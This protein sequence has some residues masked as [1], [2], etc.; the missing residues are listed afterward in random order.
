MTR[1]PDE[2]LLETEPGLQAG[3]LHRILRRD[4]E[5]QPVETVALAP[6]QPR[7]NLHRSLDGKLL[8]ELGEQNALVDREGRLVFFPGSRDE[9]HEL[10]SCV[11]FLRKQP[12]V[13]LV[14]GT[15][16]D[17]LV[18]LGELLGERRIPFP[19][20]CLGKIAESSLDP[21]GRLVEY[22][23][24]RLP[25]KHLEAPP[26]GRLPRGEEALEREA[27]GREP[28]GAERTH[29]RA[30]AGNGHD[31]GAGLSHATHDMKTGVADERGPRVAHQGEALSFPEALND[32]RRHPSLIVIVQGVESGLN[33]VG[34]EE[35]ASMPG[36]FGE[37][38]A[39]LSQDGERTRADV[40]RIA[41]GSGYDIQSAGRATTSFAAP[42]L[43][44]HA[45]SGGSQT[46]WLVYRGRMSCSM[47]IPTP[48]GIARNQSPGWSQELP[49]LLSARARGVRG[50]RVAQSDKER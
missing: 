45:R 28:R 21:V 20:E 30:G 16:A 31:R 37:N 7:R 27:V 14:E 18:A 13:E 41:D 38:R 50:E 9:N 42:A 5:R 34:G 29:Q 44:A 40:A 49:D 10:P 43:P 35:A 32:L 4:L 48:T 1:I 25:A 2:W 12:L 8:Q 47:G 36:I 26:P 22:E 11:L 6:G 3:S 33:P 15:A 23:G 46:R 39:H 19:S 24:A 17:P